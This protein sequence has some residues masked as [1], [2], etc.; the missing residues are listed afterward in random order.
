[1]KYTFL[2]QQCLWPVICLVL[3][4]SSSKNKAE[5]A[6]SFEN[7]LAFYFLPVLSRH[8]LEKKCLVADSSPACET[9]PSIT[10]WLPPPLGRCPSPPGGGRIGPAQPE[11]VVR[12]W[13]GRS[14]WLHHPWELPCHMRVTLAASTVVLLHGR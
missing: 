12:M 9:V 2:A 1:M 6:F 4:A 14:T 11:A 5:W 10:A 13:V 8:F 7:P 3:C